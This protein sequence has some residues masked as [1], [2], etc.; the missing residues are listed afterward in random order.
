M[1]APKVRVSRAR[2]ESF[3]IRTREEAPTPAQYHQY[4]RTRSKLLY[5]QQPRGRPEASVSLEINGVLHN[6]FLTL[7]DIGANINI[8]TRNLA[9]RL[10]ISVLPTKHMLST[11]TQKESAGVMGIT[12][13]IPLIYGD[14]ENGGFRTYHQFLISD[15]KLQNIY[16]LLLSSVDCQQFQGIIDTE[17]MQ[18]TLKLPETA[19][20]VLADECSAISNTR[21]PAQTAS[22]SIS[23]PV[24]WR[25]PNKQKSY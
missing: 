16:E 22:N 10:G 2:P 4:L 18:Y 3:T 9:D 8:M 21:R 6:D 7:L 20:Q 5:L 15:S 14:E 23:L 12:P 19:R 1:L 17:A 24:Q 25:S 13:I 11:S